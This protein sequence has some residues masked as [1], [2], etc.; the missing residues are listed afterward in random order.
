MQ[1]QRV[2]DLGPAEFSTQLA[3]E[4]VGVSIGPVD[5]HLL[6]KARSIV[7]VLYDLYSDYPLKSPRGLFSLHARLDEQTSISRPW[8]RLVRF[9]VDGRAPHEDMPADQALPV[10]EWGINLVIALRMHSYLML[11]AAVVEKHGHALLLPAAPGAGKSTLCT[12]LACQGWRLLSDEF[13]LVRPGSGAFEPIPRPI[14]LKNESIDVIKSFSPSAYVGP[15][16][17]NTRKGD[18]AHVKPPG[19]SVLRQFEKADA[20][21][22]VFPRWEKGAPL[23]VNEIPKAEAFMMLAMNAFNY[24]LLGE[25]GFMTVSKLISECACYQLVYS[26]LREAIEFM[27]GLV[28]SN[29]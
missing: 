14:A 21:G 22:I 15:T 25:A 19:D 12:A 10:L 13:G 23:T 26:D 4:G 17:L 29:D 11:H 6:V 2:S 18:V 9:R 27:D 28:P 7:P 16:I 20:K 8:Q 5:T 1:S 3:S 24:E